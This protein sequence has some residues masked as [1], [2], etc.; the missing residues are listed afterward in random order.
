MELYI[1]PESGRVGLDV[2]D[3]AKAVVGFAD[4]VWEKL[5]EKNTTAM[6]F[7]LQI[8]VHTIARDETLRLEELFYQIIG[9]SL[10]GCREKYISFSKK[11][12]GQ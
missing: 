10:P 8:C 1:D 5:L 2:Q 4:A 7:L 12:G 6:E 9:E 3:Q 11:H